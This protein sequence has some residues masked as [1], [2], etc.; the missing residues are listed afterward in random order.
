V[1]SFYA[2]AAARPAAIAVG[3]GT[4]SARVAGRDASSATTTLA[5]GGRYA[6][7]LPAA[8]GDPAARAAIGFLP[9]LLETAGARSHPLAAALLRGAGFGC[10]LFRRRQLYAAG[11]PAAFA[12]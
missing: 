8:L 7:L 9:N 12:C 1:S 2:A 6:P 11:L 3:L 10:R 4:A 5:D